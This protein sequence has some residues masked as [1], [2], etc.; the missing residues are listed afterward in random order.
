LSL[1]GCSAVPSNPTAQS[2]APS[3]TPAQSDCAET[4]TGTLNN[5]NVSRVDVRSGS[6][7][8][9]GMASMGQLVGYNFQGEKNQKFSY[10]P[11]DSDLCVWVYTPDNKILKNAELPMNG[12]Y[13][14]QVATKKGAKAFSMELYVGD[15]V[16]DPDVLSEFR[17]DGESGSSV[18]PS[19]SN[20]NP[21][22][23]SQR[24]FSRSDFPKAVCGD[25]LPTD[26]SAYPV[27]LYS[28]RV[29][30]TDANLS[31]AIS[32]FCRDAFRKIAKDTGEEVVQIA[33][34][35]DQQKAQDFAK[36]LNSEMNGAVVGA[37]T[38]KTKSNTGDG[39]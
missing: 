8:V 13:V 23:Q 6:A 5:A 17:G 11:Q 39:E 9:S 12:S 22:N 28:V 34:F 32:D 16:I 27:S 25:G 36:L 29:P 19:T 35:I 30:D 24:S 2:Q 37:P 26:P 10:V 1:T 31:K 38:I 7:A 33:S 15:R 20:S 4:P 21:S 18:N 14:V 3:P